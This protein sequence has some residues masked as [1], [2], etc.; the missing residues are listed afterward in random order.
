MKELTIEEK[1]RRY[2][3][4][5]KAVKSLQEVNPSDEGIQNWVNEN[6]SEL[7]ENED[8][9]MIK[10]FRDLAP[11]DKVDELYEKYGFSHKDAISWL[12]KQGEQKQTVIIPRFRVGDVITS[13]KNSAL[14]YKIKAVDVL[15]ELGEYD[16]V[17]ED[18][19]DTDYKGR[20]HKMSISKVDEWGVVV[21]QKPAW[22]EEDKNI[23][24][25]ITYTVKNSGYKHCIGVSN[26]MMITFIKSLKDRVL[27]KQEWSEE[28]ESILNE[29]IY[30]IRREPYRECD[31]EPIVDWLKELKD[32]VQHQNTWKPSEEQ[33]K[34]V[35]EVACYSSVFSEKTIDNLIS[36]SKDLKKLKG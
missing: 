14:K 30:F 18:V 4:A 2:D 7:K 13:T 29:A 24:D 33:I 28:D 35:K 5:L 19:T 15:N 25:A 26:E 32:R 6:F 1:A 27:P 21:E 16:Y 31:A 23:L 22:S 34:A 10:Y 3:E 36:L 9:T 8:E 17:V 12:E 11:F 20:I